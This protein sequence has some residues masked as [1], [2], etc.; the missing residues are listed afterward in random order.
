MCRVATH[1]QNK[2]CVS[3]S[4]CL[5]KETTDL[6]WDF[7]LAAAVLLKVLGNLHLGMS[8][9]GHLHLWPVCSAPVDKRVISVIPFEIGS[10]T[11]VFGCFNFV[12]EHPVRNK[13]QRV[14]YSI[15]KGVGKRFMQSVL[16]RAWKKSGKKGPHILTV[17]NVALFLLQYC[18]REREKEIYPNTVKVTQSFWL[19]L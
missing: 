15:C 19:I 10:P 6:S 5:N 11:N 16:M 17:W 14:G 9:A 13:L 7:D 4:L 12:T 2:F 3:T 18:K 8:F 1:Q